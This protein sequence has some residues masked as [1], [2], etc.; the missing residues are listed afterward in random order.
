MK[1]TW[2]AVAALIMALPYSP[3]PAQDIDLGKG[4]GDIPQKFPYVTEAFDHLREEVMI[5]MRDGV[6]L[7][8]VI[9]IPKT[10]RDPMPIIL[11]RTPYNASKRTL[12]TASPSMAVTLPLADEPLVRSGYVRVYQDVRGKY[13]SEGNYVLN[14]P[15]RGPLNSGAVDHTTDTWDTIDWLVKNVPNNNGRVG[16]TGVSYDGFLTLM[17]LLDPHPALKAAVPV[18]AM[19]DCWIGDDWYHNGAFRAVNLDYIY[20][21]TGTKDEDRMVPYDQ[22]D[23]YTAFLEAGSIGE[24]GRRYN[25]DRLPAWNRII[26]NPAYTPYWQEQAV[27]RLLA[28]VPLKVPTMTVHSLFDQEDIYGPIASYTALEAK[29][30]D[31]DMNYLVLGPWVHGQAWGDGSAA[32][33]IPWGS[34][35]SLYVREKVLQAFW[36]QHLKDTPPARPI[37][38]VLAFETGT[39]EWREYDSWPPAPAASP[40]R[41]YLQPGGRLAFT[42]PA[43][44][45]GGEYDE[46]V[47]DPAKPVPY[48]VR[49]IRPMFPQEDYATWRF[50]LTYDQRPFSDRP[51]VLTWVSAPLREPI[52]ISGPVAA[53][54][55][56]ST[57]GTDSD[58]VVKLIDLYPGQ[59]PGHPALGGYQLMISADILRGRYRESFD[60][61]RPIPAGKVLPYSIRMPH[62]NHTFLPGHRIMVHVQ[63]SWFPVYDRNPQTFV[64]NIAWARPE[65]F[66]RA[67]QR[68]YHSAQ[69][70]SFIDL[71]MGGRPG[72]R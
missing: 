37:P 70:A 22:Y 46:Y 42:P 58:W 66:R 20:R 62:A 52:T 49:P 14:L 55:F 19:V 43:G 68:I 72:P 33:V 38:P 26:G 61:A 64:P 56:A 30:H 6:K 29:D 47:S 10:A 45:Q 54:L 1:T 12:G 15:E 21:Q 25:A 50:W 36:D 63:S 18:N 69:A 5:P 60:T 39:D 51:D 16:I 8:T 27:D 35:T 67:T 65:D 13:K 2:L 4:Q 71:P 40:T 57:T 53:T 34:D 44:T 24:L 41:L 31:N 9:L 17:A 59:V 23:A 3:V 32:G 11:T 48:R 7:F 28:A